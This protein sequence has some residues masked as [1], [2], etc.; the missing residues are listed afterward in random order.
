MQTEG[1]SVKQHSVLIVDDDREIGRLLKHNLEDKNTKVV[2]AT[3][4]LDGIRVLGEGKVDLVLLDIR[5][6][7]FNGWGILGLLRLTE[8]LHSIPVIVVTV[9]PPDTDLIERFKP[10]DYIQKPFDV[11]DL[12]ARVKKVMSSRSAEQECTNNVT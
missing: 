7:D 11:R 8:P 6:P 4:G 3:T 2:E 9:E 12:L 5:L 10:D 1:H